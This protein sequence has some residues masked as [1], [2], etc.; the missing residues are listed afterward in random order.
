MR[1]SL[2]DDNFDQETFE[3]SGPVMVFFGAER[4]PVCKELAPVV[5]EI[6][7]EYTGRLKVCWVDVDGYRS[8]F[9]RFRLRGIP[10]LLLFKNGE[11]EERI[12]GLH[13]KEELVSKIDNLVAG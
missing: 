8:L 11:V 9:K 1:K 13:P 3:S 4:C 10:T 5:D 7:D 6:A 12:G 2:T